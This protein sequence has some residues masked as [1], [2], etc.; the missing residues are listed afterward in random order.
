MWYAHAL[1]IPWP[2]VFVSDVTAGVGD[3]GGE[4]EG[5]GGV[6]NLLETGGCEG[7]TRRR[8]M[9]HLSWRVTDAGIDESGKIAK[10]TSAICVALPVFGHTVDDS[11]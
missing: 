3:G 6:H 1:N 4:N 7:Y 5:V 8:C 11:N 10:G 9:L 2:G